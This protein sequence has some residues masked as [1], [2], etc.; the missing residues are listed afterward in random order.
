[1][2]LYEPLRDA[3]G[4]DRVMG[5]A[6]YRD[7]GDVHAAVAALVEGGLSV[8][9]VTVDTPGAYETIAAYAAGPGLHIG[10]GTVTSVAE[11]HRVADAG[12]SFVVSPGFDADVVTAAHEAGLATL[13]GVATATE[14]Q[15]ARRA[16]VKL[17]KLFPAGALGR[18]YLAQLRGPFGRAA[19][20][21]TGGVGID[22]IPAWLGAGA[23]AVALG[24]D[25]AGR[26]AP[27]SDKERAAL[28]SRARRALE[29]ARKHAQ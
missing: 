19:F 20:V 18:A 11:V 22:D 17:F 25:L 13:P 21:P 12:A 5:V 27:N 9:E 3:L 8:L 2:S 7:G 14:V 16:G 23:F 24:S 10:A 15:A 28:T 29:R 6:R 26:E 4:R 1:M